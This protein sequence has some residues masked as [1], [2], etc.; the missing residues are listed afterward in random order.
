MGGIQCYTVG[1]D[2]LNEKRLGCEYS[3]DTKKYGTWNDALK[4]FTSRLLVMSQ[5][6]IC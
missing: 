1:K 3:E 4:E 6:T 2:G 5:T